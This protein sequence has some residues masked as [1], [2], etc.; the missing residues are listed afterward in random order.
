MK[1]DEVVLA[2]G[3]IRSTRVGQSSTLTLH[4]DG[5]EAVFNRGRPL[6]RL[7]LDGYLQITK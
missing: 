5:K 4:H 7:D 3:M 6:E 2:A 1:L